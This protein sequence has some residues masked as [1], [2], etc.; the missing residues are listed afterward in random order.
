MCGTTKW[1]LLLILIAVPVM[2]SVA[3][4]EKP[5]MEPP[6]RDQRAARRAHGL[7]A[8]CKV[9]HVHP[10]GAVCRTRRRIQRQTGRRHR[11]VDHEH[12][13][14]SAWRNTRISPRHSIP[15]SSTPTS[16]C[17]MAKNAGMK[18]IVI[19]AK[20]HDGFAMF[21]SE[22]SPYNI[23]DATPFNATRARSWPTAC[24]KAGHQVRL[25]LLAGAG[26]AP[27]RRGRLRR[28]LGQG[29]GRRYGPNT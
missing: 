7:V 8:G 2:Q 26:L 12:G 13:E 4:D 17:S 25:L 23:F 24:R 22:A 9:R 28:A 19:T 1:V 6:C 14:D 18:Y 21:N 10:L 11:R 5:S 16:G 15:V 29:A 27:S 3:A 20:H